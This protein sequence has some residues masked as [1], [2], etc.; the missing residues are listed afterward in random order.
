MGLKRLLKQKK[1]KIKREKKTL[2][3]LQARRPTLPLPFGL[4]AKPIRPASSLAP[5]PSGPRPQSSRF[6]YAAH[7]DRPSWDTNSI[8]FGQNSIMLCLCPSKGGTLLTFLTM[9]KKY[10]MNYCQ[11]QPVMNKKRHRLAFYTFVIRNV[12]DARA[13]SLT[14]GYYRPTKR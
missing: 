12:R 5:T 6:L 2:L 9:M 4:T 13:P 1:N 10:E 11:Q 8:M 7:T 3:S 14:Q